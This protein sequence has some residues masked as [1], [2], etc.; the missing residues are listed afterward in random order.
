MESSQPGKDAVTEE[1]D[2]K[3]EFYYEGSQFP[4][5]LR[6][7]WIAFLI[8]MVVYTVKWFVPDLTAYLNN[9]MDL[10]Q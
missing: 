7:V 10:L 6:I 9:P 5:F 1:R 8:F 2:E 3:I 4:W